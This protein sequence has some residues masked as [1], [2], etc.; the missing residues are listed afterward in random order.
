M[1]NDKSARSAWTSVLI[2]GPTPEGREKGTERHLKGEGGKSVLRRGIKHVYSDQCPLNAD[3]TRLYFLCAMVFPPAIC[4]CKLMREER[5]SEFLAA[6]GIISRTPYGA[7]KSLLS[8]CLLVQHG[9]VVTSRSRML[10]IT[11]QRACPNG[12][13]CIPWLWLAKRWRCQK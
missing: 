4:L 10:L 11:N 6:A 1:Q 5:E 8:T 3:V 9:R 7:V 12:L 13:I 2:Q